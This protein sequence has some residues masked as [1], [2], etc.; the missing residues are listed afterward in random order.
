MM[1]NDRIGTPVQ[2]VPGFT[3]ATQS[4]ARWFPPLVVTALLVSGTAVLHSQD[5]GAPGTRSD[6][7]CPQGTSRNPQG[8]CTT[9]PPAAT[10]SK[11]GEPKRILSIIP[12]FTTTDSNAKNQGPLE[13]R[14]KFALAGDQMFDI[15]AHL[16]NLFE[17]GVQQLTNGEPHYESVAFGKR[18]I[19]AEGDQVTSCLFIYGVL[20]VALHYDP[21]YFRRE[22]GPTAART[23]YAVSRTFVTRTDT[24]K[25]VFNAPQLAG[26]LTQAGLSNL[27]YPPIDRG[28]KGT[29]KNWVIQLGYNSLFN[30][31]KEFYPDVLAKLHRHRMQSDN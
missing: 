10:K 31:L 12:N 5:T 26:Q 7:S 15:S 30:V 28:V 23:W 6:D 9:A 18:F 4:C 2:L 19:A 24:G 22:S 13:P 14:Q 27:Y 17:A 8:E 16:G 25:P 11:D 1:T 3:S 29:T 20:P 21:R